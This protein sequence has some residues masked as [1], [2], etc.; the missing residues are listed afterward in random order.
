MRKPDCGKV[1]GRMDTSECAGCVASIMRR[2]QSNDAS[3]IA[4]DL[5]F[6]GAIKEEKKKKKQKGK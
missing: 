5:K 6:S 3:S 4:R 2:E 1:A